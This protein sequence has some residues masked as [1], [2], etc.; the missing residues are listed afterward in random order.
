MSL[1]MKALEKAAKDRSEAKPRQPLPESLQPGSPPPPGTT[2]IPTPRSIPGS[3]PAPASPRT[4]LSLEPLPADRPEATSAPAAPPRPEP[5]L[6][7][8]PEPPRAPPRHEP[9]EAPPARAAR[10]GPSPEQDRAAT[11]LQAKASK[12]SGVI[13]YIQTRPLV[14]FGTLAGIF[15]VAFSIYIYLQIFH[16]ALFIKRPPIAAQPPL[17]QAPA[18]MSVS[19]APP[20]PSGAVLT[21]GI[22]QPAP[23][24]TGG[25]A[26]TTARPAPKPPL[27]ALPAAESPVAAQG[28][29]PRNKIVVSQGNA[30]PRI[31]PVLTDAYRALQQNQLEE[32]RRL[33]EQLLKAEPQNIDAHLGLAAIAIEQ[34]RSNDASEHY[35]KILELDP[36]HALAQAGLIAL[37]GRAD[38]L[39][40][41]SRLRQLIAREPSAFLYFTLGNLYADQSRWAQAQQAYFQAHHLDP[42]NP[43]YAYNLAVGLE[44]VSQHKFALGF[45]RQALAL[46]AN[47]PHVNFNPDLARE[48]IVKLASQVE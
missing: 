26:T 24:A 12:S 11:V 45:Y 20:V 23:P 21:P 17:A 15:A 42:G 14:V 29:E 7:L 5:T 48:R 39:A 13:T 32:G 30:A 36:R 9:Q 18:P 8:E 16:P 43:D 37:L 31:N 40:A 6:A 22:Q 44:H 47:R 4:E 10:A 27:G 2:P 3:T 19:P 28:A 1:L 41:E 34:G 33:Y 38:P 25:V 46:A 35:L